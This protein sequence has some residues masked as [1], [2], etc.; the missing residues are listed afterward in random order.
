MRI[1]SGPGPDFASSVCHDSIRGVAYPV[2]WPVIEPDIPAAVR[3][4]PF[5]VLYSVEP[6]AIFILAVMHLHRA[7]GCWKHRLKTPGK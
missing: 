7:P 6:D 1:G 4:F 2:L 5:G 3:R